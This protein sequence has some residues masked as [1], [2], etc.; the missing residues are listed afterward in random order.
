MNCCTA[1]L[2]RH[3]FC[4]PKQSHG[5]MDY[6]VCQIEIDAVEVIALQVQRVWC[7]CLDG[8]G[9]GEA[10]LVQATS[11]A[12][13]YVCS[14]AFKS[15]ARPKAHGFFASP[16]FI[17]ATASSRRSVDTDSYTHHQIAVAMGQRKRLTGVGIGKG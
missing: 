5:H 16:S 12:A 9:G 17:T 11:T 15:D 2:L 10:K 14:K 6:L 1:T 7:V 4:Q 13:S 3:S 8:G